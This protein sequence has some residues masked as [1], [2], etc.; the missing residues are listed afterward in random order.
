MAA[1][2]FNAP[3]SAPERLRFVAAMR[4]AVKESD[5]PF[6][7]ASGATSTIKVDIEDLITKR[8]MTEYLV[9][10]MLA[11][12]PPVA[13][14]IDAVGGPAIGAVPLANRLAD[15]LDVDW[16]YLDKKGDLAGPPRSGARVLLVDD[17][18]TSGGSLLKVADQLADRGI[19]VVG[20]TTLLDR[21]DVARQRFAE[22][23][24]DYW[25]VLTH[26]D[27]G[28]APVDVPAPSAGIAV[29]SV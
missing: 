11:S 14:E 27:L 16:F 29:E 13:R 9:G 25:P 19:E 21:A 8:G 28:L 7:L 15:L 6:K 22:R 12:L 18:I 2:P 24:M 17:V 26:A 23:G 10:Y 4:R 3:P 1:A 5:V 20:V